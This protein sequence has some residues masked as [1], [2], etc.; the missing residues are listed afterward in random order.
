MVSIS[1]RRGSDI[2]AKAVKKETA[3][4]KPAPKKAAP[5][6]GVPKK[7]TEEKKSGA[8]KKTDEKVEI[9]DEGK[10]ESVYRVKIKPTLTKETKHMLNVKAEQDKK[11]PK[12][13]RQEWFRYKKLGVKWRKPR[14]LTSKMRVGM[15]YRPPM[16]SVGFRTPK[17]VRDYHPS[18]FKEVLVYNPRDLKD[19][20]PKT[21]AARIG[22]SVGTRKREQI[23]KSADKMEIRVLNRGV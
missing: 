12:F 2:M 21:Q 17:V 23:I 6:K 8:S 15:K 20:D 1:W 10:E 16:A 3:A 19:L 14:G 13:R 7:K 5:K 22:H 11:R 4:K 9:I 18:G